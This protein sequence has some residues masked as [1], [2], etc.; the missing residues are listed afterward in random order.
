MLLDGRSGHISLLGALRE[1]R[2]TPPP[3]LGIKRLE[4][5]ESLIVELDRA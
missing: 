3:T 2:A 4:E 1:H 5:L